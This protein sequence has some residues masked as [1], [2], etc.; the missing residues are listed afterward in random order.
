[1]LKNAKMRR[2]PTNVRNYNNKAT[3]GEVILDIGLITKLEVMA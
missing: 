1:M 3:S 2:L